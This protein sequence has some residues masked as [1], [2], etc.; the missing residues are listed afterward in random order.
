M[1]PFGALALIAN[2]TY[3]SLEGDNEAARPS[4]G[5]CRY[6]WR[7]PVPEG[8]LMSYNA[9][10]DEIGRQ[11]GTYAARILKGAKPSDLPVVVSSK[12]IFVINVST[13]KALDL[14]LQSAFLARAD[15]IIE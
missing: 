10:R 11:L 4:Q 13:A 6:E 12:F 14:G 5:V 8:G 15:E 2:I 3:R 7:D 1:A 9:D